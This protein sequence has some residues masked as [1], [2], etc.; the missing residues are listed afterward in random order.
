MQLSRCPSSVGSMVARIYKPAKTAMQS[1]SA[2]TRQ[3]VLVFDPN[4]PRRVEP[5][6]GWTSS[7]DTRRQ[8]TLEFVT[9]EEAINYAERNGLAYRVIEPKA[10]R[11]VRKSYGQNFEFGKPY[12]WTH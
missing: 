3:W 9:R 1:G 10:R 2:R 6:M 5:L 11:H 4:V 12:R 8:V 7:Q